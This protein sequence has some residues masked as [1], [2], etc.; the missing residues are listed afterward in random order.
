MTSVSN[1]AIHTATC[2]Y[3]VW[4]ERTALI[5]LVFLCELMKKVLGMRSS[6]LIPTD[7]HI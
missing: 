5:Q 1:R 7:K 6:H 3:P 4:S 2:F